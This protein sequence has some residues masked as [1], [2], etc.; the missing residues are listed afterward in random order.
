MSRFIVVGVL[1]VAVAGCAGRPSVR[2]A[3]SGDVHD[4]AETPA[5]QADSTAPPVVDETAE[6]KH[7]RQFPE[8]ALKAVSGGLS[9]LQPV[10][11]RDRVV[12]LMELNARVVRTT[13]DYMDRITAGE[14]PQ[15]P[16]NEAIAAVVKDSGY[17][18]PANY[19]DD[20]QKVFW[21]NALYLQ[22]V[23]L[24]TLI[25]ETENVP[26]MAGTV[27]SLADTLSASIAK[28]HLAEADFRLFHELQETI[29]KI[30]SE[31]QEAP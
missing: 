3:A 2:P 29:A 10:Y 30:K 5:A 18:D 24:D 13:R 1:V 8:K 25:H 7:V 17:P 23:D 22:L 14:K 28:E 21:A 31:P 12:Q 9:G 4:V 15:P 16:L 27:K 19:D 6:E 26:V 20:V 11:T